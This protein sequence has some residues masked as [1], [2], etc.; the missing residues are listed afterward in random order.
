MQTTSVIAIVYG[1]IIALGGIMGYVKAH[2]GESLLTGVASGVVLIIAGL[3]MRR[4][5]RAGFV[6]A[7]LVTLGLLGFFVP[8]FLNSHKMM[9]AG[10]TIVLSVLALIAMIA[11]AR[12]R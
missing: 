5:V 10:M 1:I 4:G 11:T 2:S 12:K 8:R 7:I 6:V 9:P 3:V